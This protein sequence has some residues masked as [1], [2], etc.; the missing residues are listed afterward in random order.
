M[1]YFFQDQYFSYSICGDNVAAPQL[2]YFLLSE[3]KNDK[4]TF[5]KI[6]FHWYSS[7]CLIGQ[8]V[9]FQFWCIFPK[10]HSLFSTPFSAKKSVVLVNTRIASF[11]FFDGC[12]AFIWSR[13]AH[14]HASFVFVH[15]DSEVFDAAGAPPAL[16]IVD[17]VSIVHDATL[18]Q[19]TA[20][21]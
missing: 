20:I 1:W 12:W 19:A 9:L 6:Q 10:I 13:I 15:Q 14:L 7:C 16:V 3:L 18:L 11:C 2:G 5:Q 4:R 17:I 21:C 8:V